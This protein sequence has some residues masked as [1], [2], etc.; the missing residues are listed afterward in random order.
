M[1]G[2]GGP[3]VPKSPP[4]H[5]P[6]PTSMAGAYEATGEE[7]DGD[8]VRAWIA[9]DPDP[10]TA[11]EL[12]VLLQDAEGAQDADEES[13]AAARAELGDRFRGLLQFG[14]AGLRGELA[15]GPH[16]MNRAVVIRAAAGLSAF[17]AERLAG[18]DGDS[19]PFRVVIGCDARHGSAV[20]ARDT[21]E[22]VT[23]A[24]GEALL[25]PAAKPTPLLAFAVRHLDAD[26]GVMV[27]ASHNPPRDNGY[28]VYLGGRIVA[29]PGQGAQIVA[30]ADREIAE[31]I[32]VVPS[33]RAVPRRA[34]GIT[35]LD[36]GVE[37]AYL[38]RLATLVPREDARRNLTIVHTAL[39][40]V[41]WGVAE[42]ALR[43]AG[44]EDLHPVEA[45]REP[46]PDFPTVAFPNPEEP[47]ALDLALARAAETG[48]DLVLANDPDA[49]RLS[50]AIPSP[51]GWRQLSGDEVG[52]L[53]GAE[54]IDRLIR[55]SGDQGGQADDERA[56]M[57]AASLVSSRA[58][59]AMAEARG[60]GYATT[61]TGFKWISRTPGLVFGYEEALGYCSDPEAVRDK[62]GISAAL[63]FA[64]LAASLKASGRSVQDRLDDLAL[65]YGVYLTAPLSF[66]VADVQLIADAMARL[67]A[68]PPESLGGAAVA[69]VVDLAEG[70]G[71]EGS[72]PPTDGL[73][74]ETG[75]G[76]RV[77]VR[78]SG[79]EPKLKCYLE[80]VEPPLAPAR[81]SGSEAPPST[82]EKTGTFREELAAARERARARLN[83]M[84]ADLR[85]LLA[86]A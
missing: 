6:V 46:D 31:R 47:G 52:L 19:R 27:T 35:L 53:L 1:S 21:A 67:R 80:A 75:T 81:D 65:R 5:D 36:D 61:L 13:W 83:A 86:L 44:F 70:S 18:R 42:R 60:V 4:P 14:T 38:A 84:A 55:P 50:V 73:V 57:L 54:A 41:G 9:D 16:R 28:K 64:H 12:A 22:V 29:G 15:G 49:D 34:E 85:E 59:G 8:V 2:I 74:L 66:R 62:D 79:T 7:F 20:F 33:V 11:A 48:A 72:L 58:L 30:P 51:D 43:A 69:R 37:D 17:L 3:D 25:L 26:A 71:E 40:G 23:A 24:G 39:H 78:P 56:P 77:V 45:Q 63:L 82:G 76:D 32:E 68:E 10:A